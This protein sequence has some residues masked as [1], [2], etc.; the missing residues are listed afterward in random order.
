MQ[1][2]L[3]K[4]VKFG[5]DIVVIVYPE[6]TEKI[7]IPS[8]EEGKVKCHQTST[9]TV[10]LQLLTRTHTPPSFQCVL[11]TTGEP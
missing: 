3:T 4:R 9:H 2:L 7:T 6:T 10:D 5:A 8:L 11:R 1:L